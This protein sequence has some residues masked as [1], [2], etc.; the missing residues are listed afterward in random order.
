MKFFTTTRLRPLSLFVVS[1]LLILAGYTLSNPG[2]LGLESF[3]CDWYKFGSEIRCGEK[4][5]LIIGQPLFRGL[6]YVSVSFLL[7]IILPQ[8]YQSWKKFGLWALP[9]AVLLTALTPVYG[10][11]FGPLPP[12]DQMAVFLAKVYLI[13]SVIIIMYS[14]WNKP[15]SDI[16]KS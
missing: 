15:A 11:S 8:T 14:W 9:L 13:I 7:L 6:R 16:S 10:E 5:N 12:R 3:L 1:V 4:Y 2:V